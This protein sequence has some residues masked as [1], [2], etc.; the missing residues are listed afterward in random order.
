MRTPR[1]QSTDGRTG[2]ELTALSYRNVYQT[3]QM[4]WEWDGRR[5]APS[6]ASCRAIVIHKSQTRWKL[7]IVIPCCLLFLPSLP[8]AFTQP[9]ASTLADHCSYTTLYHIF[10]CFRK[11][12]EILGCGDDKQIVSLPSRQEIV[13]LGKKSSGIKWGLIMRTF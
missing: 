11:C 2:E 12:T 1:T 10:R 8:A 6:A 4:G 7:S 13:V 9:G 3:S 5:A